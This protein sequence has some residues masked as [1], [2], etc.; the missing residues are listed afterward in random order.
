VQATHNRAGEITYVQIGPLEI[1][2]TITTYTQ[3]S[4]IP[5]DR[6]SLEI[7]WGDGNCEWVLREN[8]PD[9]DG[10]GLPDGELLPNDIKVNF[11]IAR[12]TYAGISSYTISMNDK[13]RNGGICNVNA[14]ASDQI[15]FHIQTTV[16][17]FNPQFQGFNS[18]P[19]LTNPPIDI[20]CVGQKFLHNPGAYDP[21]GD[22]L[23]YR[24]IVPLQDIDDEVTAYRFPNEIEPGANNNIFFD[25]QTG[26]F[27][28]NAPQRECEYNIAFYV[29]EYRN[30]VAIDTL[31]R[32]MQILIETCDNRPPEIEVIEEVCVVA[33]DLLELDV[34]GTAPLIDFDQKVELT[35][36][37]GPF[38]VDISP[39]EFIVSPGF[40]DQPNMAQFRWQTECE[41]I[42]KEDYTVVFRAIDDFPVIAGTDTSNTSFLSTIK[43]IKIKVVGPPPEDVQA[44]AESNMV[45]VSWESPYDCEDAA[46][47]YFRGFTVWRRIGSNPFPIDTCTPGLAGR[48]YTEVTLDPV[49]D[50]VNGRYQFVDDDVERGRTYCYRVL[51]EFA[52]ISAGGFPFNIVESLPS[53]EICVQLSRDVPLMT[54]VSVTQTDI[55]NGEIFVAWIKPDAD[56]LDTLLNP[57][58]Y[59]YEVE[60]ATGITQTGFQ[61]I[62][63]TFTA[64]NFSDPVDTSFTDTGLNTLENAYSY[65]VPL[66]VDNES[67]PLG[68]ATPASSVFLSIASTDEQ[69]D[70]SWNFDVPWENLLY[71]V[72]RLNEMT[73]LFEEIAEVP[74]PFY[75]DEG[76]INGVEYCYYVEAEGDYRIEG[77]PAPLINL[78]QEACGVPLDSIPPC[79]PQLMVENICDDLD[80]TDPEEA[81]INNLTW[82]NPNNQCEETDDVVGYNIYY[83]QNQGGTFEI[84]E[85]YRPDAF[86]ENDTTYNHQPEIGIAGCYA[87][88]A[89]DSVGNE[90]LLSDSVCV[91]N[92]PLYTLPN[93]FTPNGDN[94]HDQ[95]L[96][97]PYRF[98]E[99]IDLKIFNRWGQLVF[100]TTD[101]DILWDGTNQNGDELAEGA[102]FYSCI[103]FE[104]RLEGVTQQPEILSGYI[105]LIRGR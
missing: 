87:V 41:H 88:S 51:A 52:R 42:N 67:E 100:E 61:P 43:V 57:G 12:H 2:A 24:L 40:Q 6:D 26:D 49:E 7:C 4:S 97:F 74:D 105:Q 31:I 98:I 8:G 48:G 46:M 85:E 45:T 11:Y 73:G 76:L 30:G 22:S 86:D 15:P 71:R 59:I 89:I 69:N 35:A 16:T 28:W 84:I 20:G 55:N 66:T 82:T 36:Q 104:Q 25:Q 91:D 17:F 54:N 58:P 14:P 10:D 101:P 102:Y 18:S 23:A 81:F 64:N 38:E 47:D 21:D 3:A 92:C 33:G 44:E 5:A 83:T 99:R 103:V 39:A 13:N 27:C 68:F 34:T 96:P 93:V 79:R 32:D 60:R 65:R 62:G 80:I 63:V 50:L 72:F 95:F 75:S 53:E 56:D 9:L 77:V 78:S 37:G 94:V 90:S 29:I 70:L 19:I 1:E